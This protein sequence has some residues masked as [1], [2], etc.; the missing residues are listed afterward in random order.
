V[1]QSLF[2]NPLAE[3]GLL[4]V[5]NGAGVA[6]VFCVMLGHGMLPVW[7][8]SLAAVAGA[9]VVTFFLLYAARRH[10]LTNARLLLV[11]VAIGIV[12]SALMT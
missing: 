12:C 6:L 7:L 1:M 9:L 4:G 2:E 8:M 11:G 5:A 10:R 3:P